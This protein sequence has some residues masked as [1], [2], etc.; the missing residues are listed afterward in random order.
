MIRKIAITGIAALS[1]VACTQREVTGGAIGGA[2]GA[3][4]GAI[5][6]GGDLEGAVIGGAI[7]AVAGAVIGRVTE[8]PGYCYARDQYGQTVVV[9]CP[10][11]Y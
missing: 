3:A 4:V 7:G 2:T 11:G 10:P 1:L 6:T 9:Q 8:R 5:A